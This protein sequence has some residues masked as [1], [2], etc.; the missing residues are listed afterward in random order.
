MTKTYVLALS[1]DRPYNEGVEFWF[2]DNLKD[3]LRVVSD[4]WYDLESW[5]DGSV[6]LITYGEK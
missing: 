1:S 3:I 2:R 6:T 5:C 4:F